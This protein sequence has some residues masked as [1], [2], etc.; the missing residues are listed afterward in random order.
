[1]SAECKLDLAGCLV[2]LVLRLYLVAVCVF[3]FAVFFF[4]FFFLE[5]IYLFHVIYPKFLKQLPLN[6]KTHRPMPIG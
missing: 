5:K 3:C 2:G 4:F 6:K 1:M